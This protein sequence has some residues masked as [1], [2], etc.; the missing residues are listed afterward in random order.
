MVTDLDPRR[1][2]TFRVVAQLG[3]VSGAARSLHL[4]QPAVTAQIR[5]LEADLGC[6]LFVRHAGGMELTEAGRVLLTYARRIHDLL[7]EAGE[8]LQGDGR[9]GRELRLGAST[10]AAAYI[11]PPVLRS[12]LRHHQPRPV[13][14]EVGNTEEALQ[15]IREGR[16]SL[17]LVEGLTRAPGLAM[18]PYLQDELVPVRAVRGP[19]NLAAVRQVADLQAATLVWREPGSGTR[20]VVERALRRAPVARVPLPGDLVLGDTEAI[21]TSV[22]LGLGI[23]FLSRWSI[24]REARQGLLEV[25][26]LPGLRIPRSF[27]WV[28][29]G[30]GAQGQAA[31]FLRHA[32]AHPPKLSSVPG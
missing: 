10:T 3:Q 19:A 20:V 32:Q 16:L 1:L 13:A 31:A 5:Q 27:S 25:I 26:A 22:L 11:L 15:W 24:Q 21:K 23:G 12:F 18:E 30:G 7:A 14:L 9:A 29:R 28:Q 17:A 6:P 4:S 8:R 2:L